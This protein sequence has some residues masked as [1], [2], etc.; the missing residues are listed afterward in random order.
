[1][2]V[3]TFG[4]L[5]LRLSPEGNE[6]LFQSER[7]RWYFGGS[8]AN[9]AISVNN[10]GGASAYVTKLPRNPVGEAAVQ[11]LRALGVDTSGIARGGERMGAYFFERGVP[12]RAPVCV[13]DRA[14]SAIAK[15]Q[16][17]DF[18]W[19]EIFRDADWFHFSGITPALGGAMPEI[20]EAACKAARERGVPVSCDL[21]Y[22]GQLWSREEACRTM[23]RLC[24]WVDVCIANDEDAEDV[25]GI[26]P[27]DGV[28]GREGYLSIAQ[29]LTER[30]GF[31]QVAL[32][33]RIPEGMAY[34]LT[35]LL[36]DGN[37]RTAYAAPEHSLHIVERVG[38][39]DA[40]C[41][42]LIFALCDGMQPQDAVEFGVAASALKHGVEGDY[43]LVSAEEVRRTMLQVR[44]SAAAK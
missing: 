18:D 28:T 20:C 44:A 21:N 8:E 27:P 4:E 14:N 17:E 22:R 5:M 2:K 33:L 12:P 39:G 36:Y 38:A 34:R 15:A 42:G 40:F 30:F 11:T 25:F 43:N 26:Q 3:V 29:Q 7:M 24:Q 10:F 31:R 1:M 23:S 16:K 35:G 41:G 6:R 19:D 32:I 9:V 37:S 13:Y